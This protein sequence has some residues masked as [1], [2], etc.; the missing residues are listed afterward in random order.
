MKLYFV[1]G[2]LLFGVC[3]VAART[4]MDALSSRYDIMSF[5]SLVRRAGLQSL[6]SSGKYTVFAPT[7]AALQTLPPD[8]ISQLY[9]QQNLPQLKAM[10]RYYIAPYTGNTQRQW[11]GE[12][13]NTLASKPVR[14]V[15]Y[16]HNHVTV[17]NGVVMQESNLSVSNGHIYLLSSPLTPPSSDIVQ[18]L[19]QDSKYS[20]FLTAIALSGMTNTL[21]GDNITVLAPT[22]D[23]F[24]KM[25]KN[26]TDAIFNN[27]PLMKALVEFHLL[28]GTI[29]TYGWYNKENIHDD[30]T[31]YDNTLTVHEYGHHQFY[32]SPF[33]GGVVNQDWLATNG[34]IHAI[35]GLK[36]TWPFYGAISKIIG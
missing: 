26:R 35:N 6:L 14:L 20:K 10:V 27:V 4:I 24:D 22:D 34:V 16:P 13:V 32:I 21:K 17:V 2:L 3:D 30:N 36:Y 9:Q 33:E 25:A 5:T 19:Q 18:S 12:K 8:V 11:K 28:P 29:Y 1:C 15:T 31:K 23:A 7:D